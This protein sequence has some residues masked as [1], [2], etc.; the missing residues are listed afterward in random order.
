MLTE[1]DILGPFQRY[2]DGV[3][4]TWWEAPVVVS[5]NEYGE[6]EVWIETSKGEIEITDRIDQD[7]LDDYRDEII[8]IEQIRHADREAARADWEYEQHRDRMLDQKWREG[9]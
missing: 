2:E 8:T 6:P 9:A 5:L 3:F 7:L 1:K 4:F